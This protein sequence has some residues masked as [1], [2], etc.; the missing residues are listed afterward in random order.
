MTE[1][2][3]EMI[4][5]DSKI[6][7]DISGIPLRTYLD[8]P[9]TEGGKA[10]QLDIA[11]PKEGD[12]PFPV[13]LFIH[14]GGW[15]Y[16]D[17]RNVHTGAAWNT[18]PSAGFALVSIN[19]RLTQEA[20]W[21]A[22]IHDCKA[23]IRFV[24]EYARDYHLDAERIGVWGNS[25]GGQLAG[26]LAV[27]GGNVNY[28]DLSMG[29]SGSCSAVQAACVWYGIF[30]F[31]SIQ[32]HWKRIM[33]PGEMP[34]H[35]D[36]NVNGALLYNPTV[37]LD[38]NIAHASAVNQVHENMP[39]M[40]LFHGTGDRVVPYLQS[41]EFYEKYLLHNSHDKI[42]LELFENAP[43]GGPAFANEQNLKNVQAFFK[44]WLVD[45]TV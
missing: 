24:R 1:M 19:Y 28:E 43:H 7:L 16:G 6:P 11:L 18:I 10:H 32:S 5:E 37:S 36:Y 29:C 44:K 8:I 4:I 31:A 14:G 23:A 35:E 27:T 15:Y 40:M 45:K 39:P 42:H 2:T 12:G 21:P 22:Q 13:V 26:I 33:K 41:V 30:D 25:A 3:I 38:Q 17:K 34:V 20:P 9:Y